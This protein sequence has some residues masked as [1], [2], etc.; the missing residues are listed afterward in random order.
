MVMLSL[1]KYERMFVA[2]GKYST[3]EEE[4]QELRMDIW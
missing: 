3:E 2:H 4:E 1:P